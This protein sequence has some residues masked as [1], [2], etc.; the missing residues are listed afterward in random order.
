MD[1]PLVFALLLAAGSSR[2]MGRSG[3]KVLLPLGDASILAYSLRA[4]EASPAVSVVYT[5]VRSGEEEQVAMEIDRVGAIKARGRILQGGEERFHSVRNGLEA[6]AAETP[7]EVVVIHDA[8]RP[9]VNQE[10]IETSV[11]VALRCGAAVAGHPMV[12]TAKETDGAEPHPRVVHTPERS[13]L[14]QVQTPQTFRFPLILS[15]Y[16]A[17]D[18]SRG[19]PTDDAAVVEAAGHEVRLVPGPRY[20]LKVTTEHDLAV[21]RALVAGKVWS[22]S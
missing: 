21:A 3:N 16:R 11:E 6:M 18:E 22:P 2:R 7:P 19:V 20:N 13:L 5:A 1:R 15:A 10:L 12:D 14:W 17:W 8:A 4:F 9:F